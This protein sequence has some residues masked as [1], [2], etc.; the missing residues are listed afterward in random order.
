MESQLI[1]LEFVYKFA[2]FLAVMT[3]ITKLIESIKSKEDE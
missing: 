3:L 2:L 1:V